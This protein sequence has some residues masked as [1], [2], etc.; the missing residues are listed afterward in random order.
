M[1]ERAYVLNAHPGIT[2]AVRRMKKMTISSRAVSPRPGNHVFRHGF[3]K[4]DHTYKRKQRRYRE[5]RDADLG[6]GGHIGSVDCPDR[7]RHSESDTQR[8]RP[9][10]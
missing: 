3:K 5:V 8:Y 4:K 9:P 7:G 6:G 1:V 10:C 2:D